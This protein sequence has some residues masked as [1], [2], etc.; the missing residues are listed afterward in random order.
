MSHQEGLVIQGCGGDP[1][2]WLDGINGILTE[3]QILLD[4]TKF[5]DAYL[6]KHDG[7]TNLLFPMD[8]KAN[9]NVGRLAMWR[10]GTH[11]TFGG[12]WLSDYVDNRLG[13]FV[14]EHQ[15]KPDCPLIG[16]DGNI[17]N[18]MGIASRTLREA[19]L[20]DQ[21]KEMC[22][23]IHASGSYGE[24]LNIIGDYRELRGQ[25]LY[26]Y[27]QSEEGRRKH[28]DR[29]VD[30]EGNEIG[31]ELHNEEIRRQYDKDRQHRRYL[32]R[33][34]EED[35]KQLSHDGNKSIP[36][37]AVMIHIVELDL[38]IADLLPKCHAFYLILVR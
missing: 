17:F 2:E 38:Q 4:G 8:G 33:M 22:Q 5:E 28:F 18:L 13:G 10:I 37:F 31:V 25:A 24:A 29:M 14:K 36:A 11:E 7:V 23:R 15:G 21:A 1:Q 6:F 9:L 20:A 26:D 30:D 3:N 27:L 35:L 16:Q 32:E 19:G 12:T 34:I